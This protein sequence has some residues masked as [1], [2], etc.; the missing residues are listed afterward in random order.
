MYTYAPQKID[1]TSRQ[2]A[3][4]RNLFV[5]LAEILQSTLE[6]VVER[7]G[8]PAPLVYARLFAAYPELEPKFAMDQSGMVRQEMFLKAAESRVDLASERCCARAMLVAEHSNHSMND[9]LAAQFDLF[10]DAIMAVFRQAL[11]KDWSPAMESAWG[12]AVGKARGISANSGL[13]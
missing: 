8:D 2:P 12:T 10:F 4:L 11:G 9:V 6:T 3:R 1:P 7:I 5:G 13:P